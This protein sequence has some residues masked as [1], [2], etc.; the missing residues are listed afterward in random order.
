MCLNEAGTFFVPSRHGGIPL[1]RDGI[2]TNVGQK[3]FF[4]HIIT[5]TRLN[6]HNLQSPDNLN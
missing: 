2:P 5:F 6:V 1:E 4:I 3:Y